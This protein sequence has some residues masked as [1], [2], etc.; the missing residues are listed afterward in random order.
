MN[1]IHII[2]QKKNGK[3]LTNQ[4][5]SFF[6]TNLVNGSIPDYQTSA[7]LMAIRLK[8]MN[9]EETAILTQ[10]MRDSGDKNDLSMIKEI[11]VDKH[12]TGGV[13]DTTTLIAIPIAAACG[14][15]IAKMSGRGLG[16]TGGTLDKLESIP[17][18]QIEQSSEQF[19]NII[20]SGGCSVIGQSGS[21]VPADKILY[22]LRDVTA[23]VDSLPLISSSIMS[24]KLASGSNAI[25]LDV[26]SGN[27]AFLSDEKEAL[28]LAQSMCNTGN[29]CGVPTA[30]FIT[31][32]NQPLGQAI[33][34]SIEVI[35]AVQIL[36]GEKESRLTT[37]SLALAAGMIF[38]AKKAP[39]FL[40]AKKQAQEALEKGFAFEKLKQM[41]SLHGGNP[42][43]LENV[44]LLPQAKVKQPL[45]SPTSGFIK[46]MKTDDI[47]RSAMLLGAGRATKE[48]SIDLSAGIWLHCE[49]GQYIQKGENLADFFASSTHQIEKSQTLFLNCIE[50]TDEKPIINTKLIHFTIGIEGV[51]E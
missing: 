24:K 26:K 9:A 12:S 8:G 43:S 16:H 11:K 34:N 28:E 38:L 7:L 50:F 27:G 20:K 30:A 19:L 44:S 32:M 33:G 4:E 17:G 6:I 31:D 49:L 15:T 36:K 29:S 3:E 39:T 14:V 51:L 42:D 25:L 21:L 40:E 10:C 18:Y 47:G 45:K 48:D 23:T 13:A 22:A 1:I 5:I 46:S 37:L 2:D 35:E 41:V